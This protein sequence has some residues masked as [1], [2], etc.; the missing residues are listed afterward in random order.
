MSPVLYNIYGDQLVEES[1]EEH[2]VT[3]GEKI[4]TS[5]FAD[6]K[7]ILVTTDEQLKKIMDKMREIGKCMK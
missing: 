7:A 4:K 3:I 6:D 5:K 1:L 2:Y